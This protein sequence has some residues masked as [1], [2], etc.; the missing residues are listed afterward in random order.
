VPDPAAVLVAN[1]RFRWNAE[2]A[3]RAASAPVLLAADGG[4]NALAELGLRPN[5]VVGDLDSIRPGVR[6]WVGED[7]MV[8]RPDQD[9][10]DL[11]KALEFALEERGLDGVTVLG[12]LGGRIDHAIGNLGLL[13]QRAMGNRMPFVGPDHRV[14]A[15]RE[16]TELVAEPGETWSFWTFDPG[17]RVSLEGVRWPVTERPLDVGGRP[18]ISNQAVATSVAVGPVGGAVV[19]M[20][21]LSPTP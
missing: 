17:V 12:A 7:R 2:L 10:T 6:R 5:A 4:A 9:R 1:G 11:D 15:V 3:D 16:P 18:S 20:R 19:A 14:V 21:W 13:A 8:L